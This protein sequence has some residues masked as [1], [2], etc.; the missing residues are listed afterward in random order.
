[1][2][3]SVLMLCTPPALA[4][5]ALPWSGLSPLGPF[6]IWIP[7]GRRLLVRVP[8]YSNSSR[9]I[10]NGSAWPGDTPTLVMHQAG[11]VRREAA[12]SHLGFCSGARLFAISLLSPFWRD[13]EG[14]P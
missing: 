4:F 3:P 9:I 7:A 2:P 14:I 8:G 13:C 6:P 5:M 10:W 11:R 12:R 1:M